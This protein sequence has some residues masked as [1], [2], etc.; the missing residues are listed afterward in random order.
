MVLHGLEQYGILVVDHMDTNL[1]LLVLVTTTLI[2]LLLII[3]PAIHI[4]LVYQ[5]QKMVLTNIHVKM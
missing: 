2:L 1:Q 3:I 4:L 5:S